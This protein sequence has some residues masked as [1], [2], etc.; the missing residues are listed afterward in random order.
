MMSVVKRKAETNQ[1]GESEKHGLGKDKK[2]FNQEVN[3]ICKPK[4]NTLLILKKYILLLFQ[5]IYT[6]N[7]L[8]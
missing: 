4:K 6:L 8:H 1:G 7:F 5:D 2:N 3:F